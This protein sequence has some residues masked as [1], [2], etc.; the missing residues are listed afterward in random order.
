MDEVTAAGG[1]VVIISFGLMEGAQR[2]L[3]D[4]KVSYKMLLDPERRIYHAFGLYRS[5]AKV[6][7]VASLVYY[8]E[9]MVAGRPLPKPYENVHDDTQQMGGDFIID[10]QGVVRFVYPSKS[11]TDR[12]S[13]S[14]I[15][16]E[17]KKLQSGV[18]T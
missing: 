16:D 9:A 12:P 14:A 4:T 3:E 8:A 11:N 1:Q 15:V 10:A 18:S 7:G 5:V 17:L 13:V 6:W 2:W